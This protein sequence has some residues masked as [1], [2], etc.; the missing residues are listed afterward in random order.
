MKRAPVAKTTPAAKR[1]PV[2]GMTPNPSP[3]TRAAASKPSEKNTT[4]ASNFNESSPV[5][6]APE[7]TPAPKKDDEDPTV[8]LVKL[9]SQQFAYQYAVSL[10][11]KKPFDGVSKEIDF[12]HYLKKFEN[13]LSTPGLSAK[14][15]LA[16]F[17]FWFIDLSGLKIARFL[18]REDAELAIV[19]ATSFLKDEYGRKRTTANEM[20]ETLM[21]GEKIPQKD[22]LAL[23]EFVTGLGAVYYIAVD[24][25]RADEF[26]KK[27]L[28]D[29][30]IENKL[31]HLRYEWAKKWSKNEVVKG[32]KICFP[33]FLSY[34]SKA[35]KIAKYTDA[36]KMSSKDAKPEVTPKASVSKSPNWTSQRSR[37]ASH[38]FP[39][40]M[41]PTYGQG[42][43]LST[44]KKNGDVLSTNHSRGDAFST[45]KN[46]GLTPLS[47]ASLSETDLESAS[48]AYCVLC[49][50]S[51]C[52]SDCATFVA[53]SPDE[54][55][56]VCRNNDLCFR[57]LRSG[58]VARACTS[59][60]RC[61][62]CGKP[63]HGALHGSTAP[64]TAWTSN[65][66]TFAV[67][68]TTQTAP[69]ES[70]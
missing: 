70:A 45:S 39:S 49:D 67:K 44:R 7:V 37:N 41:R 50:K 25:D 30:I 66:T 22:T 23:D 57:C 54:R 4:P 19:E 47:G 51:H 18:L 16:E 12:E 24:T 65:Q 59:R 13:V 1:A 48:D 46:V 35:V 62:V 29:S 11:P 31:P 27:S 9:Q 69:Q 60:G 55:A 58:H 15:R 17:R 52:I 10:R 28:F 64:P 61:I 3:S 5:V 53:L 43:A 32:P 63:H 40:M 8:T 6:V 36:S 14:L 20:L 2:T 26:D 21:A 38:E 56:T 68:T 42:D 34:L 33:D